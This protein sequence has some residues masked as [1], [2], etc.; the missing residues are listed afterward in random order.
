MA[1]VLLFG[2]NQ[3]GPIPDS[4]MTEASSTIAFCGRR[5]RGFRGDGRRRGREVGG[6]DG[7]GLLGGEQGGAA[8]DGGQ[9]AAAARP[10]R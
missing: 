4:E 1:S 3:I 9:P 10:M 7:D 2:M 6:G 5:G 8:V